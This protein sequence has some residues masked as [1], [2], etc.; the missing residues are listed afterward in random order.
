VNEGQKGT[1]THTHAHRVSPL[2]R[3]ESTVHGPVWA[4]STSTSVVLMERIGLRGMEL[5]FSNK[6]LQLGNIAAH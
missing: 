4:L 1:K 6:A 5:G 2:R 3:H